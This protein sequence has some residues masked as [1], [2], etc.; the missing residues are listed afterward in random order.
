VFIVGG[1]TGTANLPTGAAGSFVSMFNSLVNANEAFV[2]VAVPVAGTLS[3]LDVRLNGTV[4]AA[5]R[6][7]TFNVRVNGVDVG[8]P[9]CT[10]SGALTSCTDAVTSVAVGAGDLVS[11]RVVPSATAPTARMM[12]W[13]ARFSATP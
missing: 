9:T 12:R 5:P 6:S 8:T 2:N 13:S 11:I 7:Y 1:G 10:I 3:N 4:G